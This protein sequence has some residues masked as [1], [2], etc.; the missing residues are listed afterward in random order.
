[1]SL[2][3]RISRK[4]RWFVALSVLQHDG[5]VII[6][7]DPLLGCIRSIDLFVLIEGT[8]AQEDADVLVL[9]GPVKLA[10]RQRLP[11]R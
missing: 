9:G 8:H 11:V 2:L 7:D 3:Q 4:L 1:M 6:H 10:Q 5:R